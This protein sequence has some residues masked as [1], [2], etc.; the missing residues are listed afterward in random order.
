VKIPFKFMP[1]CLVAHLYGCFLAPI[2][3][4]TADRMRSQLTVFWLMRSFC[5]LKKTPLTLW[6]V[7]WRESAVF[8]FPVWRPVIELSKSGMCSC[9]HVPKCNHMSK[10]ESTALPLFCGRWCEPAHFICQSAWWHA[11]RTRAAVK[12]RPGCSVWSLSQRTCTGAESGC[13]S[14][15]VCSVDCV[16]KCVSNFLYERSLHLWVYS[17]DGHLSG[18]K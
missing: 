11:Q 5:R 9:S 15:L 7:A 6:W 18:L 14:K 8:V 2:L 3:R 13:W 16:N 4:N 17:P 12:V 1:S 10:K